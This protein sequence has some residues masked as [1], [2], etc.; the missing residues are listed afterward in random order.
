M[1]SFIALFILVAGCAEQAAEAPAQA[2]KQV[3]FTPSPKVDI[4]TESKSIANALDDMHAAAASADEK[5]Y[6]DH[7]ADQAVFLGTDASE[8][9]DLDAFKKAV[10][11][12]FEKGKAWKYRSVRRA[13]T[14]GSDGKRAWFDEDLETE[15]LGPARGSGVLVKESGHWKVAQYNLSI[16]IPNAR[17]GEVRALLSGAPRIDLRE[18]YKTAYRAATTSAKD[19]PAQATKVLSQL[20][21]EAKTHP[22]D[23][24]EFWLHNELTWLQWAQGNLDGALVEVDAAKATLDHSTIVEDKRAGLR[25][26]ELWDRAYLLLEIA[27]KKPPV[28]RAKALL[29]AQS[30]REA[31]DALAKTQKDDNG[32]AV[33]AAFFALRQNKNPDALAAAKKVDLEKDSDVQDLYVL[34]M[35]FDA[36]GDKASAENAVKKICGGKDYLMKPLI[37]RQST[38]EGWRCP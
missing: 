23:D 22:D 28:E 15:K 3:E 2:P 11:P 25:L 9:W 37:I 14:V 27:M 5:R 18:Q 31:Y 35:A 12:Y 8:R 21:A 13:I 34:R 4:P 30:A 33:L 17:F 24:L 6:F 10:H 7:F 38:K 29:A 1:R 26:H 36:G 19:D 16:P 32:I 20:V